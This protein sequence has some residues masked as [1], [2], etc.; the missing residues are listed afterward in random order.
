M[1][2][3][4][5]AI[6]LCFLSVSCAVVPGVVVTGTI[7][8]GIMDIVESGSDVAGPPK[9]IFPHN[10]GG[11]KYANI[12]SD[13]KIYSDN[14]EWRP[15]KKYQYIVDKII[16]G[17]SA[18]RVGIKKSDIIYNINGR[19]TERMSPHEAL[20]YLIGGGEEVVLLYIIDNKTGLLKKFELLKTI[21]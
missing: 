4:Y 8:N 20:S 9:F 1:K 5:F 16:P 10:T 21:S 19:F 12:G 6:L 18:E 3:I 17:G 11:D 13:I 2:K 14:S 7:I 15:N